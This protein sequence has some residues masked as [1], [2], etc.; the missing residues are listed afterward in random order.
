MSAFALLAISLI[1]IFYPDV[2]STSSR[3]LNADEQQEDGLRG[4]QAITPA[5]T[6]PP[7]MGFSCPTGQSAFTVDWRGVKVV[8]NAPTQTVTFANGM[9]V[10]LKVTD[11]A[12]SKATEWG[13]DPSGNLLFTVAMT[14][15]ASEIVSPTGGSNPNYPSGFSTMEISFD[16][17]LQGL[18]ISISDVD[19]NDANADA[20]RIRMFNA[21]GQRVGT[22]IS[23]TGEIA[24]KGD[25]GYEP[26]ANVAA[27]NP[28]YEASLYAKA[29]GPVKT[30]ALDQSL[31]FFKAN[32]VGT[33]PT[34]T[35]YP[36]LDFTYCAP[37]P[38]PTPSPVTNTVAVVP[39]P[40]PATP[41]PVP[42]T[43]VPVHASLVPVPQTTPAPF[44][45]GVNGDPLIMGLSGQLFK[46]EGRSGA[47]YSAVSSPSMQWNMRIQ[48]YET[49]PSDSN[50][51]VS[52]VGLSFKTATSERNI[53]VAVPN[54]YHVH[55][56]CGA[57]SKEYCL[58]AGSLE[59]I[60]D[61]DK[62]VI[63]GD[64]TF[65]DGTGR[66]IAFNTFHA[67]TYA[68][69]AVLYSIVPQL[70]THS[71]FVVFLMFPGHGHHRREEVVRL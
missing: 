20:V 41:V 40:V 54:P 69:C 52:G 59:L 43:P 30:I 1:A 2:G 14:S 44:S 60:I 26:R 3:F 55:V 4:L 5:P 12:P 38:A 67:C 22:L 71:M 33:F 31:F 34:R 35:I 46:F 64:Y 68:T 48:S 63:G 65:K 45:A 39:V 32:K 17:E 18:Y 51:F 13:K 36:A 61:G 15:S 49:C 57:G 25:F 10:T 58:G 8:K 24:V 6:P 11:T 53:E 66:I 42:A 50:T 23:K 21:A 19:S 7:G 28:G 70:V 27:T 62:H 47:W 29:Q 56:G 16:R 37:T 9:V